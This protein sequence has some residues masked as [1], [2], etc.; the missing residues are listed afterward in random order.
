MKSSRSIA[1]L[2][3][4]TSAGPRRI[5]G[6]GKLAASVQR[7]VARRLIALLG[8]LPVALVLPC[9]EELRNGSGPPVARLVF[10]DTGALL[11]L[12][13]PS[14]ELA[15]GD[16]YA[17]GRIAVE[18]DFQAL[19]DAVFVAPE[20]D[21]IVQRLS[22]RWRTLRRRRNS[23]RRARAN[24][25]HHYDLG[26]DFYRLWL[27][28][29]MVYTCAYFPTPDATLE[30]AQIAKMDHVARKLRLEPEEEVI[31]AGC[32]WGSL[33]LHMA[34]RYGVRVRAFNISR[35]Q[36][37]FARARARAEG[38]AGRVE[39]VD[40]DYRNVKGRCDAFVS[41]GM[42]EHVGPEHYG[43]LSR[44][45][46]RSLGPDGRGL[47]HFIG[48][49][50]PREFSPWVEKRI[51]PGAYA[52]TLSEVGAVLEPADLAVLDV[53]N[54]RLH[55]ARTLEH[56]LARFESHR[57][58]IGCRFG[59]AFVR[60]WRLYLTGSIAAFRTSSLQLFQVVFAR[61]RSNAVPWTRAD[62]Y[63]GAP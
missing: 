62:L 38:L 26:N 36:I 18:G 4:P 12:V 3:H 11:G 59:E 55:Y 29:E 23:L 46:D 21:G 7:S 43:D 31:E 33:A 24:I 9:G 54:L 42:L 20:S 6:P 16:G 2:Q 17:S 44:V 47:L 5:E 51:F 63:D 50:Q 25:H 35:E 48:R 30:D 27:D 15:F 39:F 8:D 60:S 56:W 28:R 37:D 14:P 49:S 10:H 13:S 41:V 58:E 34:R 32:G 53:E 22:A 61:A 1:S 19:V 40:D 52:P 45:I 57:K